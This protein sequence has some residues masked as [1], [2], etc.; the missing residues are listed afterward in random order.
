MKNLNPRLAKGGAFLALYLIS[1]IGAAWLVV[2]VGP[3]PVGWGLYAP[4]AAYVIGVT[5]TLRD[6]TQD[7][8]GPRATYAA[9][10]VGTALSV[11]LSPAVALASG[12]AFLVAET[13]DMAVYTPIR[14]RG[15]LV[16]AIVAS[17]VV[18]VALD[19][20]LFLWIAFG[21]LAFFWGQVWAKLIGTVAAVVVLKLIYRRRTDPRPAYVVAREAAA[22]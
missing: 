1:I 8:L 21:D 7:Q 9:I 19:S 11:L 15:Y 4:A 13:L 6:V 16:A 3:V 14:A 10:I 5:M 18:G 17:N 22:A 12:V 2:E 20:F